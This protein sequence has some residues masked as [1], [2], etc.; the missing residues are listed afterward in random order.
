MLYAIVTRTKDY[1][2]KQIRCAFWLHVWGLRKLL[3]GVSAEQVKPEWNEPGPGSFIINLFS[4]CH[5]LLGNHYWVNICRLFWGRPGRIIIY[6]LWCYRVLETQPPIHSMSSWS[7]NWLECTNWARHYDFYW[8]CF[9]W[10]PFQPV[11]IMF[12]LLCFIL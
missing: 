4:H 11:W 1:T 5:I 9:S 8:G 2:N 12:V 6:F 7:I 3:T 10:F